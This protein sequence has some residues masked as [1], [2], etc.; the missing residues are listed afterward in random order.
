MENEEATTIWKE[1]GGIHCANSTFLTLY[2]KSLAI[3]IAFIVQISNMY[4][5]LN[6]RE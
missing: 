2:V 5:R 1:L 3:R 4:H 6:A